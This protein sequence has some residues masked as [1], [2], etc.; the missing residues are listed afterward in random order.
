MGGSQRQPP[1]VVLGGEALE[2]FMA[3]QETQ[4]SGWEK[5]SES[6][7][8]FAG[9]TSNQKMETCDGLISVTDSPNSAAH[10]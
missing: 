8:K 9:T 3:D 7:E 2:S 5:Y 10:E 4:G 1:P 6:Y